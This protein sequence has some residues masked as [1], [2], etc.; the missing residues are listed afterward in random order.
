MS[1]RSKIRG[2][3]ETI[4]Q[5]GKGGP[6][7]KNNA[8]VV[9]F[10]D[11]SDA[12]FAIVRGADPVGNT[13]L[14]T[15]SYVD[16]GGGGGLPAGT[17]VVHVTAGVGSTSLIVDADVTSVGVAKITGGP[18]G[19][20]AGLTALAAGDAASVATA[21]GDAT[22]KANA[23]QA[24][25]IA[26]AAS[27]ATTK[28]NAAQAAAIA[29]S[30]T[31]GAAAAAIVTAEAY[32]DAGI[33]AERSAAVALTNHTIAGASNTLTARIANDVTGLAA[34]VATF[35]GTPSSANLAS[36]MTDETG[37]GACVFGTAPLFKTTINLNNPADTFKYVFTPDAIVADRI[38]N[39]PLMTGTDTLALLAFAQT[40]TNKTIVAASNT[41]TDT[42]AAAGD[43][44]WYNG[45]RF[46]RLARGTANQ[47][48]TTNAGATDIAW[49]AAAGGA[50]STGG[51]GQ[52]DV[53][54]GAGAWSSATNVLAGSGFISFTSGT[55]STVGALRFATGARVLLGARDSGNA[56]DLS[57]I[58]MDASDGLYLG[59][60]AGFTT[61]KQAVGVNIYANFSVDIGIGNGTYLN[62]YNGNVES[63][64]PIT[65]SSGGSSPYG[66]HGL[67]VK[68]M[69]GST[70]T[71]SA[72]EYCNQIVKVTGTGTN[73]I[74][75]PAATDATAYTKYVWNGGSGTL[76][77]QDTNSVA[78]STTLA[79]GTGCTILFATSAVKRMHT[80]FTPT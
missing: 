55:L 62:I 43:I 47:V 61:T 65:G 7:A 64:K 14:A 15:K 52:I 73:I 70:A 6:Q 33:L 9:E 3:L 29:A 23:A 50:A 49:A 12:A 59:T 79:A 5:I 35:L 71:L 34:G 80:A 60:D 1:I 40:L 66:I 20:F 69:S 13:D 19:G 38:L 41:I 68:N 17:G 22:T 76:G 24:A 46:V 75:F 4:F 57:M 31:S 42:F 77:V 21:S 18:T 58:E 26:A 8:G 2:T 37:S 56:H 45:T 63:Y 28:A 39:L 74:K 67:T 53:S 36:A 11:A 10:R 54:D 16:A 30:D 44:L 27:D 32:T 72:A 25:A 78:I 51:A 48:L